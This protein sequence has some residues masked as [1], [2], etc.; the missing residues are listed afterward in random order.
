MRSLGA[1]HLPGVARPVEV[2]TLAE[3]P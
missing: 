1:H 2:F 3:T